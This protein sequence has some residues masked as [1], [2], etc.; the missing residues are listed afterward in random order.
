MQKYCLLLVKIAAILGLI[1]S[2]VC[3]PGWMPSQ[4]ATPNTQPSDSLA[5]IRGY[6]TV[7]NGAHRLAGAQVY[8]PSLNLNS[9]TNSSGE[10]TWKNIPLVTNPYPVEVRVSAP[11]YGD[12]VLQNAR[13]IQDDT[14]ILNVDLKNTTTL[15]RL[16]DANDTQP[17]V[18]SSFLNSDYVQAQSQ[19]IYTDTLPETIRVGI[20]GN[21]ICSPTITA[22]YTVTTVDFKS[23]VKH[24]LPNEWLHTWGRESLRAGAVAI[25][26]YAWYWIEH[27]GKWAGTDMIDTTCDQVYNPVVEYESTNQAVDYTWNWKLTRQGEIFQTSYLDSC[28]SSGC[29]D[30]SE[31]A[32]MADRGYTWDEILYY[33]YPGSKLVLINQ[34]IDPFALRFHG[35]AG[36]SPLDNRVLIPLIDAQHPATSLPANVGSTDFTIEWWMKAAPGDNYSAAVPCDETQGWKK[37]NIIFDRSGNG[38]GGQYGISIARNRLV[39]GVTTPDNDSLTVCGAHLVTDNQWHH[40]AIQ[41]RFEDGMLEMYV[42]GQSDGIAMGPQGDISFSPVNTDTSELNSALFLGG[43]NDFNRNLPNPFFVGWL[44]ELRFS[45][46]LRYPSHEDFQ[47]PK[48]PFQ[49]DEHTLALYHFD[50]GVGSKILDSSLWASSSTQGRRFYGG[51]IGGPEWLRGNLFS[52]YS[53]YLPLAQINK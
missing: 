38:S 49:L 3:L 24:V 2:T 39:F 9:I 46:I 40:I 29:L 35:A 51:R 17:A 26:M 23:Y 1:L 45:D 41:R 22:T 44:D 28:S 16:P 32:R 31:S 25:K 4:A 14:L 6:V 48:D 11:G 36:D 12:W 20:T 47:T 33:F 13:L 42:D 18:L 34:G 27:N 37:G 52:P 19:T 15:Q 10:F 5:N 7:Q 53:I 30:Q 43:G 21:V 8:I 50:D